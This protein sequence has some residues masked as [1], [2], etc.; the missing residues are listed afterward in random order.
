MSRRKT[1]SPEIA[2]VGRNRGHEESQREETSGETVCATRS[3]GSGAKGDWRAQ[4]EVSFADT[5]EV[6]RGFVLRGD[7]ERD[8][9]FERHGGFTTESWSQPVSETTVAFEQSGSMG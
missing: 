6:H 2:A 7:R 9:L 1:P 8:G 3:S 5:V 4:A